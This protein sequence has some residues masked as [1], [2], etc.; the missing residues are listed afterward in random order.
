[1]D[2]TPKEP[3]TSRIIKATALV[4]DTKN[5][6]LRWDREQSTADNLA[7]IKRDNTFG[8]A[9]RS[10]IDD[11][12]RIFKRRYLSD[13]TSV[14]ALTRLVNEDVELHTLL[15]ILY[16]YAT[17]ADHFLH[18]VVTKFL[19]PFYHMGRSEITTDDFAAKIAEWNMCGYMT[20]DWSDYTVRTVAKNTAA[21]LRD[22]GLLEGANTKRIASPFLPIGAFAYIAFYL[23]RHNVSGNQL[24]HH[25]E[26]DLFLL[27][28][29]DVE[30][31]FIEAHQ[32]G[33]L[34]YYAAGSI[35]RIEF[36]AQSLEEYV[37]VIVQRTP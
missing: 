34:E 6:L 29:Q 26:W 28:T 3:Y 31:L 11:I 33:L 13:D 23:S 14:R 32:Q 25:P 5:L 22:F 18:D 7:S 16:F 37:D 20:S 21:T 1:M 35:V 17:Q 36:P 19:V 10:R 4:T 2:E 12:L 27:K 24:V 9:S 15:R 8:K 30:R